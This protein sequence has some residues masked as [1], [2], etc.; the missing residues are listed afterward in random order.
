MQETS[1]T[2]NKSWVPAMGVAAAVSLM[3][4]IAGAWLPGRRAVAL[5]SAQASV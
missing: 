1:E 2:A 3:A 4:A 5:A